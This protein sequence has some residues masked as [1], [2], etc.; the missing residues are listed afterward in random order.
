VGASACAVVAVSE[1]RAWLAGVREGRYAINA[2]RVFLLGYPFVWWP[3]YSRPVLG[4]AVAEPLRGVLGEIAGLEAKRRSSYAGSVGRV[5]WCP[6][7]RCVAERR[8]G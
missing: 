7:R 5:G 8:G 2:G 6:V 1:T 3:E 4:G